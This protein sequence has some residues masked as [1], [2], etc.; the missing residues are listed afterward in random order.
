MLGCESSIVE[1]LQERLCRDV[2]GEDVRGAVCCV[3]LVNLHKIMLHQLLDEKVLEFNVLC[4]AFFD[5]P[6]LV[7]MLFPLEESVWILMFTFLI[8]S[9]SCRLF[10][11]F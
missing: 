1:M 3:D 9:A 4:F 7:A 11:C 5:D 8:L 2:L 10:H 6:I